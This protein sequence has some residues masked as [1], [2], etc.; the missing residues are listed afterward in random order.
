MKHK[1]AE[2]IHAWADGAEIQY[3]HW[4]SAWK[5]ST[6]PSWDKN[7]EY[8]IKPEEKQPVVRW[9][10]AYLSEQGFWYETQGFYSEY[11]I[12]TDRQYIKLE[13]TRQEFPE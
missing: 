9:K 2:L 12:K 8:R 13:Y 1:H 10:W 3:R 4:G 11:E 5:D 6:S 7:W